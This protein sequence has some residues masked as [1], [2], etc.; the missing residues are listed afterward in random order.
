MEE[1]KLKEEEFQSNG[2]NLYTT[3]QR[4]VIIEQLNWIWLENVC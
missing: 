3:F 1:L 4:N 2:R